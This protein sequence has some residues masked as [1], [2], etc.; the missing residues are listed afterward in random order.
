MSELKKVTVQILNA[1][2]ENDKG[3]NPA[4]V[5]LDADT[6]SHED[7]LEIAQKVGLSE[8]AFLSGSNPISRIRLFES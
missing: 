2:T 5:V 6:L 4:G 3:G 7:K 8:T 1:F